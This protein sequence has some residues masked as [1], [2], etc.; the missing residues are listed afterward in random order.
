[1]SKAKL[2][3]LAALA[4]VCA[5]A[6]AAEG[7][8]L[9]VSPNGSWGFASTSRPAYTT[10]QGALAAATGIDEVWVAQGTYYENL[11]MKPGV[12]LYGGFAGSEMVR[13][14]RNPALHP[15]VLD[16]SGAGSVIVMSYCL[17]NAV[18][19]GF[20]IQNGSGNAS[21]VYGTT[22]GT[23]GA[24]SAYRS[25]P[26]ITNNIIQDNTVSYR[27]GAI[28][29]EG[30]YGPVVIRDNLFRRNA[31]PAGTGGAIVLGTMDAFWIEGN[32]FESNSSADGGALNL[33][34][35][36]PAYIRGN[37]FRGNSSLT[38]AGAITGGGSLVIDGNT[39]EANIGPSAGAMLLL[40]PARVTNN[41]FI[42]NHKENSYYFGGGALLL[43]GGDPLIAN[44]TFVG[45]TC[46]TN[47][48]A[49]ML[50]EGNPTVVN[51]VIVGNSDGIVWTDYCWPY[52]GNNDLFGN[53][54]GDYLILGRN[55]GSLQYP[56][57]PGVNDISADPLFVDAANGDYRIGNG[58][59]CID[60]GDSSAYLASDLAVM[61]DFDG[62]ARVQGVE[63]EIG[64]DEVSWAPPLVT[65][66]SPVEAKT[67]VRTNAAITVTF[68]R[69]IGVGPEA[70]LATLKDDA[71][72]SIPVVCS[73]GRRTPTVL[74]IAHSQ[75]MLKNTRYT[76]SLP[77]GAAL[78]KTDGLSWSQ[79][80]QLHFTTGT[81]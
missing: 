81:R 8:V 7:A 52:L 70:S 23:G 4:L 47:G 21:T 14:Q 77:A 32:T 45:N 56:G 27:G 69:A 65:V 39:F 18:V 57:V 12:A 9:L 46:T 5:W 17:E 20:T 55:D 75:N 72:N 13:T 42:G 76:L 79:P 63:I 50:F 49:M 73:V 71:G 2:L 54:K 61:T 24:I 1:M 64:L 43:Q 59:P 30:R 67:G 25:W 34:S 22:P 10:V 58:S 60:R 16:G 35:S 41:L 48:G 37:V 19:D 11:R 36:V 44:N 31:A 29:L 3:I 68:D 40:G 62:E 66:T 51:N 28:F 80:F 6:P 53:T 74:S 26:T 78:S 33:D 15:T 38:G